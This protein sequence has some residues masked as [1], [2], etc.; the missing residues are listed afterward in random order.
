MLKNILL[1][2]IGIVGLLIVIMMYLII[3]VANKN[4]TAEEKRLEDEEQME[5]LRNYN[6]RGANKN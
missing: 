6:K 3:L 1:A 4:K 5:Y 2:S